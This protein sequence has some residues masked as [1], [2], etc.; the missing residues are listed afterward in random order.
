MN[1]HAQPIP[2]LTDFV[3]TWRSQVGL[4]QDDLAPAAGIGGKTI[5][6]IP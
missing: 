2:S 6:R 4:L 1:Q 3:R 5:V